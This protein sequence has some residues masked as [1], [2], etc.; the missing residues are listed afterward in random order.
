MS[1]VQIKTFGDIPINKKEILRYAGCEN[2]QGEILSIFEECISP[3]ENCVQNKVCYK[4][5]DLSVNGNLCNFGEFSVYSKDLAKNL[6]SCKQVILFASTIGVDFDRLIL[7]YSKIS[8]AK[9]VMLQAIG[10]E[11]AESL[12]DEF[13]SW[14]EQELKV[15][16]KPRFSAGYGDLPLEAQKQIFASL[17]CA[18]NIGVT[19]NDS[20]LMSPSKSVT[21]FVGIEEFL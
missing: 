20:L 18:K 3:A 13:C 1:V 19:L 11:R 7:R 5:L 17:D 12:C 9:A 4:I 8:P 21:A 14:L 10:S 16:L 6:K 2:A 15:K